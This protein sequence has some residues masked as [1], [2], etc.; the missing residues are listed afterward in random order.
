MIAGGA[1]AVLE[2]ALAGRQAGD[3][4]ALAIGRRAPAYH[5]RPRRGPPKE[6]SDAGYR[7]DTERLQ[8]MSE[9]HCLMSCVAAFLHKAT[10]DM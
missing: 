7:H 5:A 10:E 9:Y 2:D 6:A 1:C 8:T 4:R 3:E